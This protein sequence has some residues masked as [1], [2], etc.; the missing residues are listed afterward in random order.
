MICN[1]FFEEKKVV[2]QIIFVTLWHDV[3]NLK[4]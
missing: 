2:N 4:Q 3:T 1:V